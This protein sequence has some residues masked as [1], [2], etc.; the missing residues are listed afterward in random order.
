MREFFSFCFDRITDL[1]SLPL[2]PIIEYIVLVCIGVLAFRLARMLVGDMY[3]ADIISGGIV[4]SI[5][6]WGI[7][8]GLFVFMW[9][10]V[11]AAIAA[12]RFIVKHW[13]TLIAV[14]G[15]VLLLLVAFFLIR[16][17]V[18]HKRLKMLK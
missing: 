16:H 17:F 4:G 12:Y 7:R 13:V 2:D 1:L 8:I 9:W 5:F 11:N 15:G 10:L 18:I 3:D 6:H 14:L